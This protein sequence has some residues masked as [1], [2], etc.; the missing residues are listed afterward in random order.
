MK[1]ISIFVFVLLSSCAASVSSDVVFEEFSYGEHKNQ[2]VDFYPGKTNKV[3]V[4]IHGGGWIFS[5]KRE[6]RWIRRLGRYFKVMKT[7]IFF[8]LDIG[9]EEIQILKLLTMCCVLIKLLPRKLK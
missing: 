1:I 4:W 8:L 9:M 2:K 7:L 5:G 3:L 6:T